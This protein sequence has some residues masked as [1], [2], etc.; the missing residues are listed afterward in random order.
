MDTLVRL[1][2]SACSTTAA[3]ILLAAGVV[4]AEDT[5]KPPAPSPPSAQLPQIDVRARRM[6]ERNIDRYIAAVTQGSIAVNDQPMAQWRVPIC[7]LVDGLPHDLGQALFDDFTDVIDSLGRP[8][9][10]QGCAPNFYIL[11]MRDPDAR[12]RAWWKQHPA[13]F[14]YERGE[15]GQTRKFMSTSD[16]VRVWYNDIDRTGD[17]FDAQAFVNLSGGLPV[18]TFQFSSDGTS[19]R[20]SFAVVPDLANIIVVVDIAK[21]D[22][23]PLGSLAAYIAMVGMVEVNRN[24]SFGQTPTILRLFSSPNTDRPEGLSAWD[25]SFLKA[26]YS[27]DP[28]LRFQR[29]HMAGKMLSQLERQKN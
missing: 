6:L 14:S 3:V 19:P 29:T 1:V 9:G 24:A 8:R 17:G 28:T 16:A 21:I 23:Y 25:R 12:L 4:R 13:A 7:P 10:E 15:R 18:P 27:T 26:M 5:S 11:F 20:S 2:K 22:G